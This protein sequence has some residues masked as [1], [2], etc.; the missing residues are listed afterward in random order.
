M[1]Y[2]IKPMAR[3]QRDLKRAEKRHCNIDSLTKVIKIIANGS[4]LPVEYRDHKLI[5]QYDGCRE[6]HIEPDLVLIYRIVEEKLILM[7]L[8]T[9]TH[10][11]LFK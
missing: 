6:C 7:L 11:D 4:E 2:Q 5:G 8:R 9:G 3:F 10:S 1:K